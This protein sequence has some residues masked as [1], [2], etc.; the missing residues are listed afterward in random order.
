MKRIIIIGTSCS[1]KTTLAQ[2]IAKS[3]DITHIELDAL[4]WLPN[5]VE[6][7]NDEFTE[8]VQNAIQ[9]E[10]WVMDGNYSVVRHVT[11]PQADT[12]VWLNYSFPLVCYRAL[13]R[14][15]RRMF[16]R[17]QCCGNNVE[18]FRQSFLSSNSI[19]LWVLKTYHP[20]KK[21]YLLLLQNPEHQHLQMIVLKN[22]KQTEQ[23]LQSLQPNL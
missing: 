6:R 21:R 9:V 3:L 19:L 17:E 23:F 2:N 5:W 8:L 14:T 22:P 15:I 7:D 10:S 12:I 11:W 13:K 1:G 18:S 16:T 20:V 4:H